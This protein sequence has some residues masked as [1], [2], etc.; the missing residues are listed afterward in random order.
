MQSILFRDRKPSDVSTTKQNVLVGYVRVSGESQ[1]ENTSI[2]KQSAVISEYCEQNGYVLK[3]I[4]YDVQSGSV[5][6]NR[7]GIVSALEAVLSNSADGIICYG[8]D[9]LSRNVEDRAVLRRRCQENSKLL[10]SATEPVDVQSKHG[11]LYYSIRAALDEMEREIIYERVWG[12]KCR[13]ISEKRG[14]AGGRLP[15]GYRI[16]NGDLFL[17]SRVQA[18]CAYMKWLHLFKREDGQHLYS[19]RTIARRLNLFGVKTRG[20]TDTHNRKTTLETGWGKSGKWSDQAVRSIILGLRDVDRAE[21]DEHGQV[22]LTSE[23][24][25]EL[26]D[27]YDIN[28]VLGPRTQKKTPVWKPNPEKQARQQIAEKILNEMPEQ[29]PEYISAKL[30]ATVTG[31]S[32]DWFR[33][34]RA[35]GDGPPAQR[36]GGKYLYHTT[37][38]LTWFTSGGAGNAGN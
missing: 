14:W 38:L 4:Y 36:V 16:E 1:R 18:W 29:L 7:D 15:Y 34:R 33:R 5:F 31:L 8:F 23:L 17:D 10:L 37:T 19:Y 20:A 12:G 9:R 25:S 11:K 13:K 28:R 26:S 32:E 24:V 3:A 35:S 27:R 22:R 6:E 30:A 2:P 21:V